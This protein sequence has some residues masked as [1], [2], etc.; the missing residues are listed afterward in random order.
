MILRPYQEVAVS[1]AMK[2]LD[3]Y[4]NTIVVAPTGAGKTIMLSALAGKRFKQG[5]RILVIQHRKELVEQN[6]DKFNRVNPDISSSIYGFGVKDWS[7]DAVFSMIQTLSRQSNLDTLPKIDMVVIDESHHAAADTYKKVI[8]H[9]LSKNTDCEV[10]GFTATPNR[11]DGEGLDGVFTNCAHQIEIGT[12]IREGFLVKPRAFV[13]DLG[14]SEQLKNVRMMTN[15]F[16]M[17][18]VEEIMN[19]RAHN[20]RVVTEWEEKA[21]DRKTVVFCS[22]IKHAEG[23]L[24]VFKIRGINAKIVT[25]DTPEK[26]REE[27]LEKLTYG[28]IQVV[29]NVAVLTE[30]FDSPPVSCVVL[31]RPCSYK[32]TMVQMVGRGLRTVNP[33]EF[34]NIIKK[35]CIVL[36]FGTSILSH[37]SLDEAINLFG[38][39]KG[40]AAAPLKICS[41]CNAAV[42]LSAKIC[43]ECKHEFQGAETEKEELV[44]FDMS[45]YDLMQQSPF[46]WT[47]L[48]GNGACM[49]ASGFNGFGMVATVDGTSI[50]I[51][52]PSKGP[53][54]VVSIGERI[55]ATAAADDFM[56]EIEDTNGANKTKRWLNQSASEKQKEHL[57]KHGFEIGPFDFSWTKYKAACML[58]YLWNKDSIDAKVEAVS[59]GA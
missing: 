18:Q 11:G 6:K 59:D 44:A 23:L 14:V 28:D 48:F 25:G 27:T 21:G 36:D 16:D 49:A 20:E 2:A 8:K 39:A 57:R 19:K 55:Q 29:V 47:D 34:P 40:E 54:R 53:V 58:N 52:K 45:E 50:A 41:A 56:R 10:V 46:M 43:P 38:K 24:E 33:E 31:T 9:A 37:G 3:K 1:D 7:G 15:D 12:L 13:I 32:S 4:G 51:V 5:K 22:T 42:P 35:D 30:G 26:E 17:Q